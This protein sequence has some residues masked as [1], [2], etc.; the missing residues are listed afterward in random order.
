MPTW[1]IL[2][3][4]I[5]KSSPDCRG[6]CKALRDDVAPEHILD[7]L[8]PLHDLGSIAC[9][10]HRC[11]SRQ[12]VEVRRVGVLV[13]A[14]VDEGEDVPSLNLRQFGGWNDDVEV[15]GDSDDVSDGGGP[16]CGAS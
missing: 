9:H 1:S 6:A 14:G 13:G 2:V 5:P 7:G 10:K 4:V 15:A 16:I 8:G 12:G 3:T 11:R